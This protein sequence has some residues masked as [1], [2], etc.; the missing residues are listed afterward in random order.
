MR[1]Q[2]IRNVLFALAFAFIGT[3]LLN[4]ADI[5]PQWSGHICQTP[6]ECK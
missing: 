5:K 3:S 1:N 6:A 2:K 4:A